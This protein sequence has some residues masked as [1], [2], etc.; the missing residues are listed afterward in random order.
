MK[1]YQSFFFAGAGNASTRTARHI[2]LTDFLSLSDGSSAA[3]RRMRVSVS[4]GMWT[5]MK[6][7]GFGLVAGCVFAMLFWSCLWVGVYTPKVEKSYKKKNLY[8]WLLDGEYTPLVKKIDTAL[9]TAS[10]GL[11]PFLSANAKR[12]FFS[13]SVKEIFKT[14]LLLTFI[15]L[16]LSCRRGPKPV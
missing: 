15:W 1:A 10:S 16:P 8:F 7:T 14:I 5:P 2:P 12:R 4:D 9:V 11:M 6:D 3:A 13:F